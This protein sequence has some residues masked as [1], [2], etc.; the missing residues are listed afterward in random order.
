L[1][2]PA[3]LI[4]DLGRPER[5]WHLFWMSQ[6]GGPMLKTWSPLSIGSWALAA[7]SVVATLSLLAVRYESFAVLRRGVLGKALPVVGGALGLFVAGYT[8]VLLNVTNRP[9]W[10]DAPLLGMLFVLSAAA[11]SSAV[12]LLAIAHREDSQASRAWLARMERASAAL[13]IGALAL[14][15]VWLGPVSRVWLGPW[16]L[17]LLGVACLGI[18]LPVL[19]ARRSR[20]LDMVAAALVLT[21]GLVLRAVMVLSSEALPRAG[22]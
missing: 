10:G 9:I 3:L 17:A 13:E 11:T 12:L 4:L 15:V 21:G 16:G 8:G 18:V 2:C 20:R 14:L 19:L 22:V 1:P 5:F 7:F 6:R